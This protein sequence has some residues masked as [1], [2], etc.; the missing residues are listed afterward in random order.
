MSKKIGRKSGT[1][2]ILR[3]AHEV[4][5]QVSLGTGYLNAQAPGK[6]KVRGA[7]KVPK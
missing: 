2:R 4:P 6:K 7:E 3:R 1:Q 5:P